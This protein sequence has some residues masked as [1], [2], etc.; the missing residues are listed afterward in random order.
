MDKEVVL[1]IYELLPKKDCGKCREKKC[2]E[3][4]R[5]LLTGERK[6]YECPELDEKSVEGI[7]LIL[8]E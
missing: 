5:R 2:A 4:A 7:T 6:L 8:E 1:R 3:F